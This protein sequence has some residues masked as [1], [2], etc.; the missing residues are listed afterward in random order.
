[1]LKTLSL[2]ILNYASLIDVKCA[3]K[4]II[5]KAELCLFFTT[6]NQGISSNV[7]GKSRIISRSP[8]WSVAYL[9][10]NYRFHY[11]CSITF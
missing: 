11:Y 8:T 4:T 7:L 5:Q 3:L 6:C 2:L 1:M 10:S 9:I